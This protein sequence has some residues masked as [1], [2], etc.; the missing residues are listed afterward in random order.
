M[1][2]LKKCNGYSIFSYMRRNGLLCWLPDKM[3]IKLYYRSVF[4]RRINLSN[5]RTFSEKLQW[6]K[7]HDF[8]PFYVDMVDKYRVKSYISDKVG[9][10]YTIPTLRVWD[11]V[12][13]IDL[14]DLPTSFVL[15]TTHDSGSVIVCKDKNSIDFESAKRTLSSSIKKN[16]FYSGREKPYK[17]VKPRIIAEQFLSDGSENGLI[18]YK[19]HCFNGIPR[20]ILVCKDRASVLSEDFFD[21]NWN[22]IEVRRKGHPNSKDELKCPVELKEMLEI[23]KV[24][25]KGIP[26]LRVDFYIV[27]HHLYI[28]ELTFYPASGLVPFDPDDY[29]LV[30]GN[31]LDLSIL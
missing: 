3:Y 25:A 10:Q 29:D 24:F 12:E 14:K 13:E 21:V 6:L 16:F 5:P 19:V 31:Y 17:S 22:H 1:G 8:Q 23:S 15:K 7:L 2:V 28:G 18:D 9:S 30:F 4:G 20:I 11:N 26:F 27:N